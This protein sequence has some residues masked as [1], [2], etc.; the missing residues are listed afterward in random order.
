MKSKTTA[1]IFA[2]FLG[3]IGAHKFYLGQTGKGILYLLFFWTYIPS[4]I[5]FIEMIMLLT[6]SEQDFNMR[7]NPQLFYGQPTLRGGLGTMGAT[8]NNAQS[9]TNNQAQNVTINLGS[10]LK[11]ALGQN[12]APQIEKQSDYIEQIERLNDLHKK[13]ILTEAEFS[14]KKRNLLDKL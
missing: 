4:I 7:Y 14:E 12:A 11:E 5:A 13:G 3:G 2:F 10:E 6:M 9:Q 1:A 8:T